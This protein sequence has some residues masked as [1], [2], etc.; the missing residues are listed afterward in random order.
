MVLENVMMFYLCILYFMFFHF[1]LLTG[2]MFNNIFGS[3]PLALTFV[4]PFDNVIMMLSGIFV[5]IRL[6]QRHF[7]NKN[8]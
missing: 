5:N 3:L 2:Y 6:V 4:Q 7:K 1:C 8:I